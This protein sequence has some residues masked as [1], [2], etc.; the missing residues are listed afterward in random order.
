MYEETDNPQASAS[1]VIYSLSASVSLTVVFI[2]RSSLTGLAMKLP[3]FVTYW[4][5]DS[6]AGFLGY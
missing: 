6:M 3:P 2:V 5:F 4:Q 1:E